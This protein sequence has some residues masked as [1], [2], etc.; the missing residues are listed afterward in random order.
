MPK[1]IQTEYNI[2]VKVARQQIE[3]AREILES[4]GY[5]FVKVLN[6][7]GKHGATFY[8]YQRNAISYNGLL[9]LYNYLDGFNEAIRYGNE[10][11]SIDYKHSNKD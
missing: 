10:Y 6:Q 11:K 2:A 5:D 8:D 9:K 4:N 1:D 3:K 7:G